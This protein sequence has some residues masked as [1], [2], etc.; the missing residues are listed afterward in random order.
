[1][2]IESTIRELESQL[3]ELKASIKP[4]KYKLN[5][6]MREHLSEKR[7]GEFITIGLAFVN[8]N[9]MLAVMD[10]LIKLYYS[11]EGLEGV[12]YDDNFIDFNGTCIPE[13]YLE[14]IS[15]W[16]PTGLNGL[17]WVIQFTF[18]VMSLKLVRDG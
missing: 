16:A 12:R 4:K 3:N 8:D 17:L 15:Q 5:D 10:T 6:K 13:D 11:E 18:F 7:D 2:S 1:M 9:T 14:C